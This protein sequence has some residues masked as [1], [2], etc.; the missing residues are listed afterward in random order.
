MTSG[1]RSPA[2]NDVPGGARDVG[3]AAGKPPVPSAPTVPADLVDAAVAAARERGQDVADVPLTAI[4]AAANVSRSTLLRRIGGTRAALDAAVRAAG[5]DPGGRPP[6]RERAVAAAAR[7]IGERGLG[8][9]TLEAVAAAAPCALPSL[10]TVFHGRDGL[11]TAVFERYGPVID[12]E[13]LAAA[14][15]ERLADVV[16][17][18][19]RAVVHAFAREPRVVPAIFADLLARPQGP[20]TRLLGEAMPRVFAGISTLLRPEI[21]A[22]RLRPLPM[23]VLIQLIIGPPAVHMMTRPALETALGEHLPPVEESLDHFTESFLRAAAP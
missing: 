3:N 17:G 11:L 4:A 19:Q 12:V 20:G 1:S 18:V 7:L 22:G 9:V 5:I 15:P 6:V 2:P 8:A 16:R 13:A 23:P 14:P 21:E 10:H